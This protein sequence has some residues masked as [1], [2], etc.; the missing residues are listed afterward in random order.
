MERNAL[1]L[2]PGPQHVHDITCGSNGAGFSWTESEN[3]PV[4]SDDG[5]GR[6]RDA[7]V[8]SDRALAANGRGQGLSGAGPEAQG[9][10]DPRK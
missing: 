10:D 9:R 6:R 3:L 2:G 5:A 1:V 7:R 8:R 4:D